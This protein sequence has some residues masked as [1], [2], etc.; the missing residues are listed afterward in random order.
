M[1][2]YENAV[3]ITEIKRKITLYGKNPPC[4]IMAAYTIAPPTS[5][6]AQSAFSFFIKI[7]IMYTTV[8]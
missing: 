2:K 1:G 5:S 8:V 3:T 7:F 6:S 4:K